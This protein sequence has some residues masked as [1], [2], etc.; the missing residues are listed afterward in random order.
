M[1][2]AIVTDIEGTTTSL[3][4]VHDVLFPYAKQRMAA[5]V[6]DHAQDPAVASHLNEVRR[7]AGEALDIEGII[8]RLLEWIE[9]DKKITPLKALQGM[10]WENGY[11]QGDF[12]GHVYADAVER[13]KQWHARG[14]RL[15]IFSSGSVE[16]QKLLFGFSDAGDL[17]PLFSGYFDTRIG[18]K[19]EP[20]AYAAITRELGLP[21]G[22]ILFL[23][24]IEAEL[25]AARAGGMQTIWLVRGAEPD[26]DAA[27]TQVKDFTGIRLTA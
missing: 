24:D 2:K 16:A 7:E 9:Q 22:D 11:R 6:R 23:S 12:T 5:F 14:I 21:T 18:N 20:A 25:D 4:F 8:A 10:I 26:P 19:R 3:S 17:T 13:L 15:Y 1:I 27:H